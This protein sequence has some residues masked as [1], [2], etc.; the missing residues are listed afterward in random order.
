MG[1]EKERVQ[2]DLPAEIVQ[3]LDEMS[4][5]NGDATR[6]ETVRKALKVYHWIRCEMDEESTIKTYDANG[7]VTGIVN[8]KLL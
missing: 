6:A 4:A 1:N 5:L 2:F 3:R 8:V 7:K